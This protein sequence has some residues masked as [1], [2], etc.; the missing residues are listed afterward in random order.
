MQILISVSN[1]FRVVSEEAVLY[2]KSEY[3]NIID[4]AFTKY[5]FFIIS[6]KK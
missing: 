1:R 2:I 3:V 6:N 4:I 5:H